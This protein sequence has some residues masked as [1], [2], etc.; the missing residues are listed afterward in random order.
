MIGQTI[1]HYKIIEKLGE[2]PKWLTSVS[3]RVIAILRIPPFFG[4]SYQTGGD[5]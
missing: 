1:S 3:Q 4:G 5:L 2:V